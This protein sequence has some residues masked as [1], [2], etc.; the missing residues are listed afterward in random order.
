M[1]VQSALVSSWQLRY[2]AA[3]LVANNTA[4]TQTCFADPFCLTDRTDNAIKNRWNSTLK[5]KM[6]VCNDSGKGRSSSEDSSAHNKASMDDLCTEM[7]TVRRLLTAVVP[8][9]QAGSAVA[10]ACPPLI[11]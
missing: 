4:S 7:D 8:E 9:L 1:Q 11:F 6:L 3:A 10:Q 2:L 5:R